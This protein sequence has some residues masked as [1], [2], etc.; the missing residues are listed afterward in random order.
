MEL[1]EAALVLLAVALLGGVCLRGVRCASAPPLPPRRGRSAAGPAKCCCAVCCC[2][3]CCGTVATPSS[4]PRP[5]TRTGS[6]RR[7]TGAPTSVTRRLSLVASTAA[8]IAADLDTGVLARCGR[9]SSSYSSYSSSSSSSAWGSGVHDDDG[10]AAGGGPRVAF[11]G[12]GLRLRWALRASEGDQQRDRKRQQKGQTRGPRLLLCDMGYCARGI[13]PPRGILPRTP[14]N[15][16]AELK[17]R[18]RV[19][20]SHIATGPSFLSWWSVIFRNTSSRAPGSPG[21]PRTPVQRGTES[22]TGGL[23]TDC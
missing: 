17:I 18:R 22:P 13:F 8:Q 4:T 23:L 14:L 12:A 10:S 11:S 20:L 7:P 16:R 9:P 6:R 19:W 15:S 1:E 2:G 21:S 5:T 3:G